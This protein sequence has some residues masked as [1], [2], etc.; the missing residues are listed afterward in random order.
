MVVGSGTMPEVV[1]VTTLQR[2]QRRSAQS[3]AYLLHRSNFGDG[4]TRRNGIRVSTPLRVLGEVGVSRREFGSL[5]RPALVEACLDDF[6]GQRLTSVSAV[7]QWRLV[8]SCRGRRGIGVLGEVLDS[9]LVNGEMTDSQLEAAFA[10][11]LSMSN[12]NGFELHR[13]VRVAG[14]SLEVDFA[15]SDARV[16]IELDGFAFHGDRTSFERDR[17]RDA[18]LAVAGW[19]VLRFTWRDI[20]ERPDAVVAQVRSVLTQRRAA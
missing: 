3:T 17:R 20:V 11:L 15:H 16:A 5:R 1:E 10:R 13:R 6:V 2:T 7:V 12:L 18:D 8:C 19:I 14:R 4:V 9:R